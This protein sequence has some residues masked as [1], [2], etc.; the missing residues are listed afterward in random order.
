MKG[1]NVCIWKLEKG[2]EEIIPLLSI[3]Y[4]EPVQELAAFD[5]PE[6]DKRLERK[7]LKADTLGYVA[8]K[9][10]IDN[11]QIEYFKAVAH[12]ETHSVPRY[13]IIIDGI[14]LPKD[15]RVNPINSTVIFADVAH[16]IYAI[17]IGSKSNEGRLRSKLMKTS[18]KRSESKWGEVIFRDIPQYTFDKNFYY[19]ILRN[20]GLALT[21]D[22]KT[23]Y[24][25]DVRGFRSDAERKVHSYSGEGS[26]ISEEI[27][28]KSLVSMD[29][30]LVSLYIMIRYNN[31]NY[32][33]SLDY[34]GRISLYK[35]ECGEHATET[36]RI[37][38]TESL[39]LSIYFQIIP[40]LI[41]KY[42]V[43]K[44]EGWD[45]IQTQFKKEL[46]I[47]V[48]KK[49]MLQNG[50]SVNELMDGLDLVVNN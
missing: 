50:L 9:Y 3:D 40:F 41:Q 45:G 4:S 7:W 35:P 28:L 23:M 48:I 20:K 14:P 37:I 39:I 31:I 24:L 18:S 5:L 19:W 44:E 25:E 12:M 33:F 2:F 36:P 8:Q 29:E 42:N 15:A 30:R 21:I 27:P 26:N 34:D 13:G 6:R 47:D 38:E 17:I 11:S 16:S 43:A 10:E 49:L 1:T 32:S 22:E 46:S